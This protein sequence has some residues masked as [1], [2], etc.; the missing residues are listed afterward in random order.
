MIT[1]T[2]PVSDVSA[3]SPYVGWDPTVRKL[4]GSN[5]VGHLD[6]AV[7]AKYGGRKGPGP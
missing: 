3:V 7:Q 6:L 1:G 2:K 4:D 5:E